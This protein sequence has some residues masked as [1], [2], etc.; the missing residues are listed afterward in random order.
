MPL[1]TVKTSKGIGLG[2]RKSAV[3]RAYPGGSN[4]TDG[5]KCTVEYELVRGR[6]STNF[7]FEGGR[8]TSITIGRLLPGRRR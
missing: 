4:D 1:T 2:S 7:F 3:K 6:D 8:A 5:C